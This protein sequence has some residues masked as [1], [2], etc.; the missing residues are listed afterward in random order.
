MKLVSLAFVLARPVSAQ[1]AGTAPAAPVAPTGTATAT[2]AA[3]L[4]EAKALFRRGVLLLNA[5]DTERALEVFLRSRA[6]VPSAK[7]TVNAAICLER[8]DRYDEALEM[9]EEVLARFAA[10]LDADDRQSLAP[11]MAGLRGKIGYV[12]LSSNVDGLVVVDGKPRGR[13]PLTTALRLI[14]GPR[15]LRV[16]KDGYRT[17]EQTLDVQAGKASAIDAELEPLAGSG[18]VRIESS[19]GAAQDVFI[20]GQR[21]GTTPFEGTLPTGHHVLETH[22]DTVGSAPELIE[23]LAGRTLLFRVA[24]RPLGGEVSITSAPATAALFLGTIPLAHGAWRGRLPLGSYQVIGRDSGYFDGRTTFAAPA[25]GVPL[26]VRVALQQNPDD[27][28][29][30]RPRRYAIELGAAVGPWL[31]PTLNAGTERDC[32]SLCAKSRLA[33]GVAGALSGGIRLPSGLGAEL[34]LGYAAFAQHFSR[35]VREPF[36]DQG[37]TTATYLLDQ[38]SYGLGPTVALRATLRRT[39]HFG[40]EYT[41][42][43]GGGLFIARYRAGITGSAFTNDAAVPVTSDAVTVSGI[44]PF[45]SAALGV[46]RKVAFLRLRA[47]LGA[48]FFVGSGPELGG[49]TLGV[50]PNCPPDAPPGAVDC[51]PQSDAL[52]H[53]RAHGQFFAFVPELGATYDF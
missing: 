1:P 53:E 34:L 17:F 32:P 4:E 46:A 43:L 26:T 27:P 23:V 41:G 2:D 39:T 40:V 28:R 42:A 48:W 9:Y 37:A 33:A 7:N 18:A 30:P 6:L 21:I 36:V 16:V 52:V 29:W 47:A 51:A 3:R 11:V 44:S 25:P 19:A 10:D 14:P 45:V 24:P 8:L 15:Q 35:A 13:L 22:S 5:G 31:A 12:E 49:P 20:D 50:A 38:R